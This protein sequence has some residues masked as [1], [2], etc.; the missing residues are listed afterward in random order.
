M[1]GLSPQ[2]R[3][4]TVQIMTD[5]FVSQGMSRQQAASLAEMSADSMFT[6]D[7]GEMSAAER[8]QFEEQDRSIAELEQRQRQPQQPQQ[9]SQPGANVGWP[10]AQIRER[11]IANLTQPAGTQAS[12]NG[13]EYWVEII[14]LT[15]A[16]A[17]TLQA[18]KRQIETIAGRTMDGSGNKFS[19]VYRESGSGRMSSRSYIEIELSGTQITISFMESAA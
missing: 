15:G 18:L 17:N 14:Y 2:D 9:Q 19:V 10:A 6:I 7:V 1:N 8:R 13:S 16:N 5:V 3:Q 4:R 12:Y 11:G